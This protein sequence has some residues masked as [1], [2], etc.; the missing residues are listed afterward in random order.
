MVW[1]VW[2]EAVDLVVLHH[3]AGLQGHLPDERLAI[4]AVVMSMATE[5]LLRLHAVKWRVCVVSFP[6]PACFTSAASAP[7]PAST[8]VH[9]GPAGTRERSSTVMTAKPPVGEGRVVTGVNCY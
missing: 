9:Q 6:R 3:D 8:W 7:R 1:A 5:R 2:P 4:G